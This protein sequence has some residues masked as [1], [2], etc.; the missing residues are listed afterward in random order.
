VRVADD[1]AGAEDRKPREA[2]RAHGVFL[3]AHDAHIF[4]RARSRTAYGGQQRE[5]R[6]AAIVTA[7]RESADDA[8]FDALEIVFAPL[9]RAFADADATHRADVALLCEHLSDERLDAR[10]KLCGVRITHDVAHALTLRDGFARDHH[11]LAAFR[12]GEQFIDSRAADLSGAAEDDRGE[13]RGSHGETYALKHL[14]MNSAKVSQ[15][16]VKCSGEGAKFGE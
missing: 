14:T 13:G 3:H 7:A 12:N 4:E 2:D 10:G 9:R 6:N 5:L 8:N 16:A 1:D 15:S 11:D